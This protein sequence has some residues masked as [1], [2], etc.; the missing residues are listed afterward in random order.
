[1]ARRWRLAGIL[2]RRR[3]FLYGADDKIFFFSGWIKALANQN[4]KTPINRSI[5][6]FTEISEHSRIKAQA[7]HLRK[8]NLHVII[9]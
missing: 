7:R 8:L 6:H 5:L 2:K 3:S 1:M 4:K 9:Y